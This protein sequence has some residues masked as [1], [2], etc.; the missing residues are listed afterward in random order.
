ML[1]RRNECERD[2]FFLDVER[3]CGWS[4]EILLG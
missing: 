2:V 3:V 4:N 1:V